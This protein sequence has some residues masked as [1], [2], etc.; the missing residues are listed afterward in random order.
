[1]IGWTKLGGSPGCS[2]SASIR[3]STAS[4]AASGSTPE[5]SAV[6]AREASAPRIAS[7]RATA[8]TAGGRPSQPA[9]HEAGH[10]RRSDRGDR[11]RVDAG[12]PFLQRTD[13]L[14]REQRVPGRGARAL[15]AD[16]VLRLVAEAAADQ[17]GDGGRAER[18]RPERVRGSRSMSP[19]SASGAAAVSP[20]RTA[21]IAQAGS[22]SIRASR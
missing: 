17:L 11:A 21:T 8:A 7:A 10:G 1:M 16:L 3:V 2:R 9:R 14:P 19:A 15:D 12:S 5:I 4:A 13:E 6:S 18:R 20:V 22:S